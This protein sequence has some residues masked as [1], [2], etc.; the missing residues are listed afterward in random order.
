LKT[1]DRW[2]RKKNVKNAKEIRKK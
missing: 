2:N 1:L